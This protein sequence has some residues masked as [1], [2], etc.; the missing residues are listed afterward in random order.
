MAIET[1][2]HDYDVVVIGSGGAGSAAAHAAAESGA[3]VLV[4]SKDPIGCSD[5]KIS[6]GIITLRGSAEDADTRQVLSDNLRVAGADLPDPEITDAFAA[7]S[8]DAYDWI[9]RQ[10]LRPDIDEERGGP[11]T[12]PVAFGGHT[13]RR[14]VVHRNSGVAF[15]H[16]HWNAVVQGAG[17]DYLE[18]AWV[19]DLVTVDDGDPCVAGAVI[20]DAGHGELLAIRAPS[21]VIASGGLG[22]MYFPKTDTMR[23]NTGDSYAL[24]LRAGADLVDMEQV[25]FLPFCITYPPSYEG[26]IASEPGVAGYLGVLRDAEGKL[27]LDGLMLRTRAECAA[28]MVRAVNEGRGT[29]RGGCYLDLTANV[30]APRSGPYFEVFLNTTLSKVM[31][32]V[33]QAM[34]RKATK[35]QE[36]WEVRPSAHYCMGGVRVGPDAAAK[37]DE[38][39]AA[40]RGLFS[41]GQA[42]GGVF[43]ANR[44]GST[45]LSENAVFGIR[46]GHGAAAVAKASKPADD[47]VFTPLLDGYR[48]LFG[49]GSADAPACLVRELQEACWEHIGPAR[50]RSGLNTMLTKIAELRRRCSEA[51][52]SCEGVWNQSFID[53]V[54]LASMLDT[55]EAVARAALTREDS[56]GAHVRLDGGQT[57]LLW[58]RPWSAVVRRDAAD[59]WGVVKAPRKGTPFLQLLA[60]L[61]RDRKRKVAL[62]LLRSLPLRWRDAVIEGR[63][64]ATMGPLKSGD[65][66]VAEAQVAEA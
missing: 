32:T 7:D 12:V 17:I 15:S 56:L 23:G 35:C 2:W 61:Y 44:L 54:E 28:A 52:V 24:A 29:E 50:T 31:G 63:Y 8:R 45:A 1:Q 64:R 36:W 65:E 20:Y 39:R 27:L 60:Y 49:Q 22:T 38:D 3:R 46:A 33:R 25:Q 41:A 47:A 10:G 34:G 13:H 55:A 48:G 18:D 37:T 19:L 51:T 4:V 30:A 53:R 43:G 5:T 57:S 40:V 26:L 59:G 42:M 6:E 66:K 21:V 16:A 11:Q 58:S 62:R 14:S 9:R